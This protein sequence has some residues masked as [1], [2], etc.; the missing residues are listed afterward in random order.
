LAARGRDPTPL[1]QQAWEH[2]FSLYQATPEY[3][4]VNHGMT[5][6]EFK[7]IFWFEYAHRLWGRG[8]G[9]VVGAPMLF[10]L[11]RR[12][13]DR[14]LVVRLG[15]LFVF[16]GAQ[17]GIGWLMVKSGLSDTPHVSPIRLVLHL[18]AGVALTLALW[19]TALQVLWGPSTQRDRI[20]ERMGIVL[21]V[22]A[23]IVLLSGGLVAGTR[24]GY[25]HNTFPLMG[26][27]LIPQGLGT[28][29]FLENLTAVQFLHRVLAVIL[30]AAILAA[31][32][33]VRLAESDR[34]VVR[35]WDWVAGIAVLQVTLGIA[36]LLTQVS[37]PLAS[38]H[39]GVAVLLVGALIAAVMRARR[40][41]AVE[42]V[43]PAG[44]A[45][46]A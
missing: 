8:I 13:I 31:S 28:G 18:G 1:S 6:D 42:R 41:S 11:F 5:L 20:A 25:V 10:F 30:L 46:A 27:L 44:T 22:A 7:G 34:N 12:S 38:L 37:I 4:K 24:A 29:P 43:Q 21:G 15:W 33:Y 3:Q 32:W 17:G 23:F 45:L 9:V 26:G 14:M 16:G 19:W 39:Q 40:V 2:E 36:T 35:A